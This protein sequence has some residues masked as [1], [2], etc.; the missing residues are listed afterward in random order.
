MKFYKDILKPILILDFGFTTNQQIGPDI[1]TFY[2]SSSCIIPNKRENADGYI[3]N[4]RCVNYRI[5]ENG[6][7]LDCEKHITTINKYL[8]LN[9]YFKIINEKIIDVNYINRRYIGVEDVKIFNDV[10]KNQILFIGTGFHENNN[11]GIVSG[12]Y[13]ILENKLNPKEIK[14]SF[15]DNYCEK[16]WVFMEYNGST[17]IVYKWFPLQICKINNETNKL[18]LITEKTN[19]PKIFE[20]ARGSTCGFK[21]KNELWFIIH[22]VSYED[23]RNYYHMMVVFDNQINLLRYSA[24]F[25]FEGEPIEYCLGLIVEEERVLLSYS[26]WDR[27]TKLAIYSKETINNK[28]IYKS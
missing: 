17:H 26:V 4:I 24:P 21:Y 18:D 15:N 11:I 13:D 7:Y 9:K 5:T 28:L 20:H 22:I 14:C 19:M 25:K 8:E 6:S 27:T 1:V 12:N 16:N 3:M 2:S 10:N 23:P